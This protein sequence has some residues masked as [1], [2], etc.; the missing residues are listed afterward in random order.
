[1]TDCTSRWVKASA[2]WHILL[3]NN[4]FFSLSFFKAILLLC[5]T[6]EKGAARVSMYFE[7]EQFLSGLSSVSSQ[8]WSMRLCWREQL[9]NS[10]LVLHCPICH[11]HL[12]SGQREEPWRQGL[13]SLCDVIRLSTRLALHRP[14]EERKREESLAIKK[15]KRKDE[16]KKEGKH[17]GQPITSCW[18]KYYRN[19]TF[20]ESHSHTSWKTITLTRAMAVMWRACSGMVGF[21]FLI[22]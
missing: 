17:L 21:N 18:I 2:K 12:P 9:A 19:A 11:D 13:S 20:Y 16:G 3:L 22:V 15:V 5:M 4:Q 14:T 10:L 1:M 6:I 7:W 8:C